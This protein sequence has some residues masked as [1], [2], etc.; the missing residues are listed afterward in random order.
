[1]MALQSLPQELL[2]AIASHCSPHDAFYSLRSACSGFSFINSYSFAKTLLAGNHRRLSSFTHVHLPIPYAAVYYMQEYPLYFSKVPSWSDSKITRIIKFL[3]DSEPEYNPSL[4]E[5]FV[6][7]Q[8]C[9]HGYTQ[10]VKMLI[11]DNRVDP[12]AD[13]YYAFQV[14]CEQGYL[15]ILK[16]LF[17]ATFAV[18]DDEGVRS[19]NHML[20]RVACERGHFH[21]AKW[22][23]EECGVDPSSS[24]GQGGG[25]VDPRDQDRMAA[26]LATFYFFPPKFVGFTGVLTRLLG[27]CLRIPFLGPLLTD[28]PAFAARRWTDLIDGMLAA[29]SVDSNLTPRCASRPHHFQITA[30]TLLFWN[31]SDICVGA[32]VDHNRDCTLAAY[33]SKLVAIGSQTQPLYC[34]HPRHHCY[35]LFPKQH[36]T[37]LLLESLPSDCYRA[38]PPLGGDEKGTSPKATLHRFPASFA[39][40][41]IHASAASSS[42]APVRVLVW[43]NL[44]EE[45]VVDAARENIG[46]NKPS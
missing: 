34:C 42:G 23:I 25:K 5:S 21:V 43:I 15:A 37:N 1:M 4:N 9:C 27:F 28:V 40:N 20:M 39:A 44:E 19:R 8:A 6:L 13:N 7:Q 10:L 29:L 18:D 17:E 31:P 3:M 41:A 30:T 35:S 22:L 24:W 26:I 32:I 45:I 11:L 16:A 14:A 36:A 12:T 46:L 2:V 33:W 38:G